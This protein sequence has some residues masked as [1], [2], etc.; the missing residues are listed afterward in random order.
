[1]TCAN[2]VATVERNVK[3]L[4]GIDSINVNLSS[5]KATIDF[6]SDKLGLDQIVAK[7]QRAGY[8][9]ATGD[10]T[11]SIKRLADDNDVRRLERSLEKVDGITSHRASL[12][13]EKF[14][15]SFI[16]TIITASEIKQRVESQGFQ[17]NLLGD[18]YA[19]VEGDERE[20]E[21]RHQF[22]LLMIGL[23]FTIPAFILSMARDF[24][25]LPEFVYKLDPNGVAILMEGVPMVGEWFNWLL[26]ALTLPVQFYVGWQY[27]V[28]AYK[29]LANG[30]ANMDVLIAMGSSAAFLYSIP[31]TLGW[32]HGHVYF[33]TAA[34]IITLIRLGKYLEAKAKGRTS[35]AI[36]K[37]MSLRPKTAKVLRNQVEMDIPV[38]E[39]LLDDIV[40]VKPGEKIPTDGVVIDGS[41]TVDESMLTGESFPAEKKPGSSLSTGTINKQGRLV[42][43]TTKVG[44]DTILSQIIKLV[45]T[46]Q[47]SKAPIQKIADQISSIFVPVVLVLAVV[48]FVGWYFW[49]GTPDP[50]TTAI[51]NMVAVLVIACPC[52]MGLA[53]PTAVMVGTGKGAVN[54]ILFKNSE[55]LEKAGRITTILLDKTGTV[56][57]GQPSVVAVRVYNGITENELIRMAASVENASE[58]PLADAI[59]SKSTELGLELYP[60]ENFVY[61]PGFGV[62]ATVVGK[63]IKI[64][65][66]RFL[67][68]SGKADP[69]LLAEVESFQSQAMTPVL[70]SEDEQVV[71]IIAIADPV[72]ESSKEAIAEFHKL[73]MRVAM[74]TG[75]NKLTAQAIAASVGI[76]RVFS[77]VLPAGKTDEVK[78]LQQAGE[79]VAMVGDGINDA[80][81]LAQADIGM[82]IGTGTDIAIAAAEVTLVKGDLRSVSK[83][84]RL[85]RQTMTTIK[86]NLFW[87]FIYNILLI[88]AA[89]LGYLNPIL[90]AGAMAFSSVFVVSNSLRLRNLKL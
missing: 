26:F 27:Y 89:M 60:I 54:G 40:L 7:I 77:D 45:E 56:T 68:R 70:I 14:D 86:Q 69:V 82:A 46:A 31:I 5:E 53:T 9:V 63:L 81:A 17:A 2:C 50:L 65:N 20:K 36:K 73:G 1:M 88:P 72:K 42:Y 49:G 41:S 22:K 51:I 23:I 71:G 48:T 28:G 79:V 18:E 29:A 83:A 39:V 25:L 19:D 52:A 10:I 47:G 21:I 37:L 57:R 12:T 59:V 8:G 75:D 90:A 67:E 85:S 33:E 84:F 6:D 35:D 64:G 13:T 87:A 16:P 11:F 34:V 66:N 30:S 15:V 3:K 24:S 4:D 78:K 61:D 74:L 80:P 32:L 38:E 44:K 43:R 58:H 62:S 76:D 55:I